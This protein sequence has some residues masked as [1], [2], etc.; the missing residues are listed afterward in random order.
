MFSSMLIC[1]V[2]LSSNFVWQSHCPMSITRISGINHQDIISQQSIHAQIH[3][4]ICRDSDYDE[5]IMTVNI[6]TPGFHVFAYTHSC[7]FMSVIWHGIIIMYQ[8]L[9]RK[10]E[11]V[12]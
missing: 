6:Q 1:L 12:L 7:V 9:V 3:W 4:V 8:T 11:Y 10:I 2:V 5:N